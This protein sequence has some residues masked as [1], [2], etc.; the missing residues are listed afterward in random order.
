MFRV[1]SFEIVNIDRIFLKIDKKMENRMDRILTKIGEIKDYIKILKERKMVV[2]II[3]ISK[4][5]K[6][7]KEERYIA[8]F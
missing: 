1:V 6:G 8:Y 7:R 3:I 4:Q 5:K 2:I